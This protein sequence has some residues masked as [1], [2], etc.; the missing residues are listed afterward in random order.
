M[1]AGRRHRPDWLQQAA[2]ALR[3]LTGLAGEVIRLI[4]EIRH[5][6]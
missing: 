3:L 5:I 1:R 6:Q 4:S 2:E